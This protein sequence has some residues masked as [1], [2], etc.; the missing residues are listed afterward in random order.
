MLAFNPT[1]ALFLSPHTDD[2]ELG[3]GATL[4][5]LLENGTDVHVAAFSTAQQSL[6]AGMRPDTLRNEFLA[7]MAHY[8]LPDDKLHI[9]DYEVRRLSEYRQSILDNLIDL[10]N[11]IQPD[12]VFIPSSND[13]HQDHQ[14]INNESQRAF[15]NAT[16]LG[17]ELPWNNTNFR[18]DLFFEVQERHL[19]LKL[20]A[21]SEYK[22]QLVKERVYFKKSFILSLATVRGVQKS[23][24][25][26][27]TF[28]VM[29]AIF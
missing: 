8:E 26:A 4:A 12:V 10:R 9:F 19:N 29:S 3:C 21:L 15:K 16:L 7:A 22:S 5:R 13:M 18:T 14:V 2:V 1:K 27:E 6:P 25:Y 11:R 20:A 17:Y 28:E 24:N 23:V